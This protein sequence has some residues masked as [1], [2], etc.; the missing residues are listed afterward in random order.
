MI[1]ENPYR[2]NIGAFFNGP[3]SQYIETHAARFGS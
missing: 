1:T 2:F 3:T